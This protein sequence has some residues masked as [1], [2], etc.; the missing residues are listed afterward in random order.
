MFLAYNVV[1]FMLPRQMR[2]LFISPWC[3]H[4]S[5]IIML[6]IRTAKHQISLLNWT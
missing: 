1:S 6:A 2:G 4:H 5:N 3:L